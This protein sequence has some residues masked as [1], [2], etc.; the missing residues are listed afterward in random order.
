MVKGAAAPPTGIFP[1][2]LD[3]SSAESYDAVG[4]R[5]EIALWWEQA[6][7]D[8]DA[9]RFNAAGGKLYVAAF[10]CHQAVEKALKALVPCHVPT[11]G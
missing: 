7:E 10:L 4:M 5:K 11:V 9:G 1:F 8:L 2:Y 3:T 6:Q